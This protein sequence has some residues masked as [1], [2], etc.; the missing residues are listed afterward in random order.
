ML[1]KFFIIFGLM[2]QTDKRRLLIILFSSIINGLFSV[3][4]IASILPFISVI[5]EPQ[6]I[7][8]HRYII[9]FKEFTGIQS[10]QGIVIAFGSLSFLLVLFGNIINAL[11][12]WIATRFGYQKE[13]Q[14]SERLLKIYLNSDELAF[15]RKKNSERVKSIL[16]DIDRV[17]LDTLFAMLE[18][19]SGSIV[20]VFIFVLLLT[21]DLQATLVITLAILV[22]YLTIYRLTSNKLD[23][24]GK[25]Y[26][27][28][29][30]DIYSEVLEA[31][32]LQREIKLA[33]IGG[34]FIKRYSNSFAA[35]VNNRLKYELISL[36]PQRVI[37]VVAYGSILLI[38]MFFSLSDQSDLSAITMIGMY[39][40]A[41]YRLL[42][43]VS[44]IFDSYEQIQFGSAILKKLAAEFNNELSSGS[45]NYPTVRLSNQ[46]CLKNI[47]FHFNDKSSFCF[48]D[49]SLKFH[50]NQFHCVTG[51]TG[52]GKSTLLNIIAGLYQPGKGK[53]LV[54]D[55]PVNLYNNPNWQSQLGFVPP[56]VNLIEASVIENIA[57]GEPEDSI[58]HEKIE[59]IAKLVDLHDHL[60]SLP[61]GYQS[62]FG[63]EGLNFSTGQTQKVGIAR[64]LYRDP[65]LLLLDESTDALD[66]ATEKKV[67]ENIKQH[68]K[69]TVIF[70]SH[71]PSV[72]QFADQVYNLE[73]TDSGKGSKINEL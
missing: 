67:I 42:P 54:D 64:A 35:M 29:E 20:T 2:D 19:I 73:Q 50:A 3:V 16:A 40:F 71:R 43:A 60:M 46:L 1:N 59:K 18:M 70:V 58:D 38:A 66:L 41:A 48:K 15:A 12:A 63:D 4:G 11:D 17:I 6:L 51:K 65:N 45:D 68:F 30:T 5:S 72:Q 23:N 52:C 21:V 8:S 14:L 39:A 26:A 69:L 62:V 24:L 33:Q 27:D 56:R 9:A 31:L 57:L 55:Q 13:H 36:I 37:E 34:Y 47:E 22:A 7:E 10:Y 32:K 49:L 61:D 44:D 53:L 25:E 28:L